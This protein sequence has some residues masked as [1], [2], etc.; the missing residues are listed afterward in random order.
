MN[1]GHKS[2]CKVEYIC[3]SSTGFSLLLFFCTISL[4]S[5]LIYSPCVEKEKEFRESSIS[6]V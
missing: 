2:V 4:V 1:E 6:K 3:C 5:I